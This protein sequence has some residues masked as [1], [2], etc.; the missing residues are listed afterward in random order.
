[1]TAT[2]GVAGHGYHVPIAQSGC[3]QVRWWPAQGEVRERELRWTCPCKAR[4]YHLMAGGGFAW[5]RR[6]EPGGTSGET[7]RMSY[8]DAEDLWTKILLGQAR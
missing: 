3:L 8:R 4:V 2:D 1:M 7:V 5:I 6:T